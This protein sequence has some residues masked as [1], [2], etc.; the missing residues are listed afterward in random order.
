MSA[1]QGFGIATLNYDI[2]ET[3]RI[4][5]AADEEGFDFL[6]LPEVP[7]DRSG[8]IRSAAIACET[9]QIRIGIG[10]LTPYLR[11]LTSIAVDSMALDELSNGRFLLGLGVPV[12]KMVAYGVT[13][14][15]LKP[16]QNMK[17]AYIILKD[18]IHNRPASIGS[19]YFGIPKGMQMTVS[20]VPKDLPIFFGVVNKQPEMNG[21][22]I[23]S[24]T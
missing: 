1:F 18:L 9:K 14:K 21:I 19:E 22:I 15:S 20:P 5:K 11:H 10:I 8:I 17:D 4:A 6:T 13:V 3:V 16:L 2:Q 23:Y 12:W 24:Q 7:N